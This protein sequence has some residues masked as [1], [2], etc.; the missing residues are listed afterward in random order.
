MSNKLTS[1]LAFTCAFVALAGPAFP[2]PPPQPPPVV[3]PEIAANRD[4]TLRLLAPSAE[5]MKP[6]IEPMLPTSM[7]G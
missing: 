5:A 3:S 2:Q 1:V 7:N 6:S 4:V